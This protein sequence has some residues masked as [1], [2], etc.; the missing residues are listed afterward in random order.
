MKFHERCGSHWQTVRQNSALLFLLLMMLVC[1]ALIPITANGQ[2]WDNT[3]SGTW[4]WED[5]SNWAGGAPSSSQPATFITNAV[6]ALNGFRFR[7]VS[8]DAT[9]SGSF[10]STMTINYLTMSAPGSGISG[11]HNALFLNNSGLATPLHILDTLTITSGGAV[12][13]TNAALRIDG[14]SIAF[15][16]DDGVLTL[17]TSALLITTNV[18]TA[19]G[20][21]GTGNFTVNDGTWL[22]GNITVGYDPGSIGTL[23]VAGGTVTI[24]AP[25]A[26]LQLGSP[27]TAS[28]TVL[29]SGG[30]L[31]TTN[32]ETD[33]ALFGTAQMTVTGG[34]WQARDVRVASYN[35]SQG[36]LTIAGGAST[37]SGS[38]MV[39]ANAIAATGTVWMTGGQLTIANGSAG[40]T[41]VGSNGVGQMTVSNGLW[42]SRILVV[43]SQAGSQGTLAIAGGTNLVTANSEIGYNANA[44]GTVWMTGG[45]LVATN[46]ETDVGASG[47]GQMTLSNGTWES[48]VMFVASVAGSQGTL[49]I[50]GGTAYLAGVSAPD[51]PTFNVGAVGTGT[52]WMTGGQLIATNS[53]GHVG[54]YG[55]GRMAVSNGTWL[56]GDITVGYKVGS[57]GTLTLAGGTTV[58]SSFLSAGGFGKGTVW[59]TG[60][61]LVVTNGSSIVGSTGTG[62]QIISNGAWLARDVGV[63]NAHGAQGTLTV[64]GGMSTVSSNLIIG[65]ADCSGT[66]IVTVVGGSLFVTNA[67]GNAVLD[68]ETGTFTVNAGVVVVD[69]FVMT[70]A[71]AHFVQSGG[72]FL[73]SNGQPVNTDPPLPN[74]PTNNYKVTSFGAVGD[75]VSDNATAIQ[76]TINAA[77]GTGGTVEIP[78]NGT[79][80]TYLCGPINLT[81]NENLAIDA[82]ATLMMLPMSSWPNPSTPFINGNLVHDV[83]ISGAGTIDGQGTNWWFP[84]AP[85][86]PNFINFGG[87]TNVLIQGVTLQNPPTFHIMAKSNNVNVTIQAI[88]E[89]TPFDSPNTDGMDL[90]SSNVLVRAC[91][92]SVGD[93]NI[94]IGGSG[95]PVADM[96]VSNCTFGAGHGVSIGSLIATQFVG[97]VR[98]VHDL[99]VSN[100]TFNGTE[101]GIH[102]KSDR[103][104]GGTVQNA[105]YLDLTMSNVVFP[106][107]IYANYNTIG[108]PKS[109]IN[110]TPE[111]A[112]TNGPQPVIATTPVW[113][114][115][116]IRNVTAT[117][118]GGNIAGIILGLPE[119]PASNI[120]VSNVNF[121]AATN[122][123]CIYDA[124]GIQFIDCQLPT[125]SGTNT[126]TLYNAQVTI[127]NSAPNPHV[128]TFGG[129]AVPPTNNVLALFN[130]QAA[131][132][133]ASMLGTDPFLTLA[134]S[135][136]TVDNGLFLGGAS[137]LNFGVGTN[138]AEI[139]V[140]G[141]LTLGGMLNVADAGGLT[142]GTYALFTYSGAL[143]AGG[144]TVG[145]APPGF[146]YAIN[147]NTPGQV[148]LVVGPPL[149]AFQSWQLLYFGSTNC[150]LCGG[151][152]DYDG[153]GVSNTNEFLAGT[154]PANPASLF[155][156]MSALPQ[157][158]Q[159]NNMVI[160]WTTAGGHTNAVQS[161]AGA[162]N[163]SYATNNFADISGPIIISGSGDTT[164][165]Y[166]DVGGATNKP[167]RYYR[168]RL[169][170]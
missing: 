82:G 64:A 136:V 57:S 121:S 105:R 89:N 94:E 84:K 32:S 28:G 127:T 19:V 76:N 103:D 62:S 85:T 98:G 87:C 33:I 70:N 73:Y 106:I 91:S 157:I 154:N 78:A 165:N 22:A 128:V 9:T 38:L 133:D 75:G 122:T 92:I 8:I 26:T 42:Q 143:G 72:T 21:T 149:G 160:T 138:A 109:V 48:P 56:A 69:Q 39:G 81:N 13:I 118:I 108:T 161:T 66:G 97:D 163:G 20:Y 147:T 68:V 14:Q 129:L 126:L 2:T 74:I 155:R 167:A 124:T 27:G 131:I 49:T 6:S 44:T 101:Y 125:P 144:L 10:P 140:T 114:D 67:A 65:A 112:A 46:G 141:S 36:T 5:A 41:S 152:A 80:S 153:D 83:E 71:C 110:F 102:M 88:T 7:T 169:V 47:V 134:R 156:I 60:G 164:T 151:N 150:A 54:W 45:L 116:T 123:F 23:A 51:P 145:S 37:L 40:Y 31:T 17:N 55:V 90:A 61:Q 3:A 53:D 119:A 162:A 52:L 43:G 115:I 107:A 77:A 25:L 30:Q 148:N 137:T 111:N 130:C 35:G 113:R 1:A 132:G 146:S 86:R 168:V 95:G 50:A 158:T 16:P 59:L 142:S 24:V 93:D 96:T 99:V 11:S 166:V 104:R 135:S 100:C 15:F 79:L 29:L 170:P 159:S 58:F 12:N 120:T 18:S 117:A 4:K 139:A 63:G 34:T